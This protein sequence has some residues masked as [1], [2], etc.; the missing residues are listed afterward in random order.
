MYYIRFC[1]SIYYCTVHCSKLLESKGPDCFVCTMN[2]FRHILIV[3][4]YCVAILHAYCVLPLYFATSLHLQY[5]THWA[6]SL[7]ITDA[8]HYY[9]SYSA[10]PAISHLYFQNKTCDKMRQG[11][12]KN[13]FCL[14]LCPPNGTCVIRLQLLT[15]SVPPEVSTSPRVARGDEYGWR[16]LAG[17]KKTPTTM[18]SHLGVARRLPLWRWEDNLPE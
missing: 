4:L 9:L 8:F 16:R 12:Q 7:C 6:R 2:V 14:H 3:C 17:E 13:F 5:F 15:Q 1:L 10:I 18:F 11:F